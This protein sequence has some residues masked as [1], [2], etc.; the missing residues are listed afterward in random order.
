MR[1]LQ[2]YKTYRPDSFRGIERVIWEVAESTRVLGHEHR[3]LA[4]SRSPCP[5]RIGIGSH[6]VWRVREDWQISSSGF[7]LGAPRVYRQLWDWAELIQF[8][9]PWP[10][11]DLLHLLQPQRAR[12]PMIVTYHSD[13][14]RQRVLNPIYDPLKNWFLGSADRIVAT[15]PNYLE[16][17]PTL[18]RHRDRVTVIPIGLGTRPPLDRNVV[19]GWRQRFSRPFFLFLGAARYYKGLRYL[20][21]ASRSAGLPVVIAGPFS[22]DELGP[23]PTNVTV[24]G[25]VSEAD[26]EALLE[27][28]LAL[29]L[30]SHLRS[31]AY[32]VVLVEA[33]R[34]G[35]PAISAAI[36]TGTSYVNRDGETGLEVA[37]AQPA[38]LA[39]A[40][41]ALWD[42]PD[43]ATRLGAGA[44]ARF[45]AELRAEKMA[46]AYD[47][48][49][50][51]LA[52]HRL[53][54]VR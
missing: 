24:L 17:S 12:K 41:Q 52:A 27:L 47:R 40:M 36:G 19:T 4:L 26:K 3:V 44:S 9:F 15:S 6:E 42:D 10:M 45:R 35:K 48:L 32:G 43:L 18:Q 28:C 49:Y 16:T 14:V 5:Q 50:V 53:T 33:A 31:E 2:V 1:I 34:A 8:H 30:P 37:P 29:V 23:V 38:A 20:L 39:A 51:S 25:E 54:I 21:E 22:P 46:V 13:V 7:S 11:G